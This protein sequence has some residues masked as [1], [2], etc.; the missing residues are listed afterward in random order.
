LAAFKTKAIVFRTTEKESADLE[1]ILDA[2][3]NLESSKVR[4]NKNQVLQ[5]LLRNFVRLGPNFLKD[6][7]LAL[8]ESNR[9]LLSIGRNINQVVKK[10]HTGELEANQLTIKYLDEILRRVDANR[11]ALK[12]LVDQSE[13]RGQIEMKWERLKD[14]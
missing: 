10:I 3:N 8:K 5:L 12:L 14:D 9:N 13:K 1:M 2:R 7:V 4:I 6:E 11:G